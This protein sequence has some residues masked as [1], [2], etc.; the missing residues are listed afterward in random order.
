M[1]R[2]VI[3][4]TDLSLSMLSLGGWLTFGGSVAEDEAKRILHA[5]IDGGINFLDLADVYA[6]GGAEQVVGRFLAERRDAKDIVVSSKV[7]FPMS[8]DPGDR[9]LSRAHIHASIDRSL[10]RLSRERLDLYFCHREDPATPLAETCQAMHDLVQLGK[11]RYWGTSCW[12]ASTLRQAHELC[13]QHGWHPP[14]VEQPRY[15]LLVRDIE[16]EVVP[17]VRSLGMGIV[18]FSPL[19]GGVLT[20]KYVDGLPPGSRGATSDW[21]SIHLQPAVL[22]KVKEFCAVAREHGCSPAA[23][24]LRWAVEQPGIT[25]AITGAT[26]TEQLTANLAAADVALPPA[27]D[28]RLRALFPWSPPSL[29]SQLLRRARRLLR[30]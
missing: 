24:A 2:R 20:G 6:R 17:T 16:Q 3:P 7:F 23:L 15:S 19:A 11:V 4:G 22:A 21:V 18:V 12:R 9:G 30:R 13:R 26:T 14:R 29:W 5:A 25:S 27:L 10:R 8:D 28:A 1:Q